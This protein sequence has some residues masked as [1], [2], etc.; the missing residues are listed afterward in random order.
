MLDTPVI[1]DGW[2][3]SLSPTSDAAMLWEVLFFASKSPVSIIDINGQFL[4][5]N[6]LLE[7]LF[8]V[9]AGGLV[10]RNMSEFMTPEMLAERLEVIRRVSATGRPENA[11]GTTWGVETQ[12]AIRPLTTPPGG[13]PRVLHVIGFVGRPSNGVVTTPLKHQDL[14]VLEKLTLREREVLALIGEGLPTAE[15]AARLH[16]SV[17]TIEWHRASLGAKLNASNRIELAQIAL[18]L[19]LVKCWAES[20]PV[21]E[22]R[23][24]GSA[25]S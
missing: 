24:D 19:G 16:R 11:V 12:C 2:Q 17:K 1:C 10:G 18:R 6:D 5:A 7:H 13:V 14:G 21:G 23:P 4:A 9:R 25:S 20:Q 15:I 8:H 22:E 3:P